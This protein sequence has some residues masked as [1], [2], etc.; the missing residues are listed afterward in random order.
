[1]VSLVRSSNYSNLTLVIRRL[2]LFKLS[3]D[4][5]RLKGSWSF[6]VFLPY[7]PNFNIPMYIQKGKTKSFNYFWS[8][9]L[10][11][12]K[13]TRLKNTVMNTSFALTKRSEYFHSECAIKAELETEVLSPPY[14][15]KRWQWCW[16]QH[17]VG[18]FMM[19]TF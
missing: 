13:K 5:I 7:L 16:W 9:K 15:Y 4:V 2:F 14:V 11:L 1:M 6:W 10:T 3:I 12:S 18:D 19:M 17:Y 8:M